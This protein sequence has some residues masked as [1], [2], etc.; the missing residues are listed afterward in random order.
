MTMKLRI[1][2]QARDRYGLDMFRFSNEGSVVLADVRSARVFAQ[3]INEKRKQAGQPSGATMIS[4]GQLNALALIDDILRHV[5]RVYQQ[6]EN[7]QLLDQ[8]RQW[9][10]EQLDAKTLD[11]ALVTFVNEFPPQDVYHKQA[12]PEEYLAGET[13][14]VPNRRILV[15]EMVMVWLDNMNSA[16]AP[17]TELFDDAMLEKG[18]SYLQVIYLLHKFFDGQPKFGPDNQNLIDMLRS[19]AVAVP[20]SLA[21]QLNY[22]REKWGS[23]LG[24]YLDRLIG[25]LDMLKEEEKITFHGPGPALVYD[26]AGMGLDA[27]PE[28]YSVDRE[29]MP[30]LVMVAKS[31]YVWID[32]L[33]KKY[34][35]SIKYLNEIPDEE[36]DTLS[37]WGFN[38]LWLI[39]LWERSQ[40]SQR[41][42]QLTGNPEA[43]ASAY[44]LLDYQIAADLGG[45][46]AY[47]NLAGRA[48][49]RGIRLA[50]D[51]VPNHM[52]IDSTWVAEHPD[53]FLSLPYSP[54]PSYSFN[55]PDLSSDGRMSIFLE[56]HYYNRSD[57]AVVFKRVDRAT[58]E[59]RYI[60]HGNDG[61]SMPWNDT[62]QLDYLNPTV[63]E[64]VIQT[65]LH[66]ARKFPIIR[67]DAAMTLAKRHVERLWFPEPG[68]GGAIASRSEH[69]LTKAQF[70][71]AMPVEFWREV[72]ERVAQEVPDTLLLAEAFW[73]MEGYFV[74]S[75]GMHRVYNSA[76][77]NMLKN[78]DNA[79][80]RTSIKNVLEWDPEILKRF[81]NFM[82][83]PDEETAVA[84][85]GK[86]DKYFGV[87]TMMVTLPGLP[88]IGH[89]QVEGYREKYGMEY[90]KA[91]W[92]EQP[93]AALVQRHEREIFPLMQRRHIFADVRN[94]LLY[95]FYTPEGDVNE[96]VFAYSNSAGNSLAAPGER[97]L[98]IYNNKFA[99]A[100]GWIHTSAPYLDK[101]GQGSDQ[102][103]SGERRLMQKTLGEGLGLNCDEAY[104]CIYRDH[105]SG[106]EHIA[107]S[108]ELCTK[109]LYAELEAFKYLV[110][111]DFRE[112]Q[113]DAEHPYRKLASR[114]GGRGVPSMA[115][116]LQE[117]LHPPKP[118]EPE[119]IPQP[120]KFER[121][122]GI[123]LHPTSLPGRFGIGDLGDAA[124]RFVDF[125]ASSRQ[126]YWQIMPLGPTSYGD[127]PYQATSAFAGNP[128]LICL[129]HLVEEHFLAPWDFD[130]APAF[131]EHSVD[132][133]PV[134]N[135]KMRLLHLAFENFKANASQVQKDALADFIQKN[136]TWLEDYALFASLKETH[137]G[138]SWVTWEP[139]IATRQPDALADWGQRLADLVSFHQ[140][141]QFI[142]HKQWAR[143]KAYTNQHEIRIIGDIPIFVA[144]DS[145]DAW[146]HQELFYCDAQGKPTLVAGV[147]PDFFSATGQ[148]WGNPLYRWEAM[149][150]NGYAWWI[151]RF[152][153]ALSQVDVVR[154]DHFR[155][156]ESYWA[157]P[158]GEETA[159]HGKWVKGPG[160][161][162]FR[163]VERVLGPVPIIAEDLGL[164]TPKV[165]A[166]LAEA[167]FPGM[168][169]L[170]FAFADDATNLYLPH[171]HVANA[172][173][174]TGTHDNDTSLGWYSTASEKERAAL[175]AYLG[176]YTQEINWQMI[177][178]AFMS[179]AHTA[180]VPL[181][182]VLGIG[183]EGRM[184]TP[185]RASGNWGW[186]YTPDMLSEPVAVRLR[187]MTEIYGRTGEKK[188]KT[189]PGS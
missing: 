77:M 109:G 166:L 73:M 64:A 131:P 122:S 90:R 170:Q 153:C 82:N 179:V 108:Q 91:Y 35:R 11:D 10:V 40:A 183:S 57:A 145:A 156:F 71:A 49:Q 115:E 69:G 119:K 5:A 52:G 37:R 173:V 12:S 44:S 65:I 93:D 181:Q 178:L 20:M 124:Y 107:S 140:F 3:E 186:R 14:G 112:V 152:K 113:D 19:P 118:V 163:A 83:N 106:L 169:V 142:F 144:L 16:T 47:R 28:R 129:E 54:F 9:L 4:A 1:S 103:G 130:G 104:F 187:A 53:W 182:D 125:L 138:A 68:T 139:E 60:Y 149:A 32:Q 56:D 114:L 117:M 48:W 27:E 84:Q 160:I 79:K 61:T 158:A 88:M 99:E 162:L 85:F 154:L 17:F 147:P 167:G 6:Q 38:G 127:S 21:G 180:L 89:G 67:F 123:L 143:L 136:R 185:G 151:E 141:V 189:D 137:G 101:K 87:C 132:Y 39:G 18:T 15:E 74:R 100:R 13:N 168:K 146:A 45:E 184:N 24:G 22:I 116:A 66:V 134:I 135:Y 94:F 29:W 78:E 133:G 50:S 63:R 174:Y 165:K 8:A 26:F 164:I 98:V 95:D 46:E 110:Y 7:P 80:Y 102:T 172:V 36:L 72:V 105:I 188:E 159:I 96:N 25:S 92:D 59:Q 31:T 2:R 51:M 81:V 30:R 155:G 58:G 76:F 177:R 148:L 70:E 157:V 97:G 34:Q 161:E 111:L 33:S 121:L 120:F 175:K 150:S 62:A 128:L 41:I 55:G 171:N 23:L 75:L 86:D 126:H 42:K 176:G 43:V